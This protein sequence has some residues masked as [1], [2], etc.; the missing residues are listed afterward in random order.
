[1]SA[2]LM[3]DLV[4]MVDVMTNVEYMENV[5]LKCGRWNATVAAAL[6]GVVCYQFGLCGARCGRWSSH[7]YQVGYFN[8]S[9]EVLNRTS[10]HTCDRW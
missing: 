5:I 8:L 10:T 4:Y 6:A 9:S 1:M 3:P 2:D 7:C